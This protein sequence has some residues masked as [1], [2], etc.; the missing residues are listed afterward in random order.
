MRSS[1]VTLPL[2]SRSDLISSVMVSRSRP[3]ADMSFRDTSAASALPNVLVAQPLRSRPDEN[4][5]PIGFLC[6]LLKLELSS[7]S[8]GSPFLG[9]PK[10]TLAVRFIASWLG[11][12]EFTGFSIESKEPLLLMLGRNGNLEGAGDILLPGAWLPAGRSTAE[13]GPLDWPCTVGDASAEISLRTPLRV[14]LAFWVMPRGE[15]GASD[16]QLLVS[17]TTSGVFALGEECIDAS[18]SSL[19]CETP[20]HDALCATAADATVSCVAADPC[21]DLSLTFSWSNMFKCR[22]TWPN[23][24]RS[25][26]TQVGCRES[27]Q[28]KQRVKLRA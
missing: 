3:A 11:E 24:E 17:P 25:L 8:F 10:N 19:D 14:K 4:R 21:S 15:V 7:S 12:G 23:Y 16:F 13:I 6:I 27:M 26:L 9:L 18:E 22:G 1:Y 28:G 5:L 20:S 2:F